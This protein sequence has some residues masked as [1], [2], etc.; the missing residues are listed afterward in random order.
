M[1]RF[2]VRPSCDQSEGSDCR[3]KNLK[4]NWK[5]LRAIQR[6]EGELEGSEDQ[7]EG[8]EDQPKG[9]DDQPGESDDQLEGSEGQSKGRRPVGGVG[10]LAGEG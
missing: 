2:S 4:N 5:S 10:G 1:G 3:S 8:F 9:S 7:P 6:T